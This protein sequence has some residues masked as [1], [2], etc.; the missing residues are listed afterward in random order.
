MVLEQGS[1]TSLYN[2][3]IHSHLVSVSSLGFGTDKHVSIHN[4]DLE[5]MLQL[6]WTSTLYP[7]L[8]NNTHTDLW[9]F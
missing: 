7:L 8:P 2:S 6:V 4:Q 5:K 9:Y 3:D 1:V